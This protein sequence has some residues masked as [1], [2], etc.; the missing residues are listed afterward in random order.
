MGTP[1]GLADCSV[2]YS[3]HGMWYNFDKDNDS[4]D[5]RGVAPDLENHAGYITGCWWDTSKACTSG[6]KHTRVGHLQHTNNSGGRSVSGNNPTDLAFQQTTYNADKICPITA[7]IYRCRSGQTRYICK[8][9]EDAYTRDWQKCCS[10]NKKWSPK[11]GCNPYWYKDG[12]TF[13]NDCKNL[14]LGKTSYGLSTDNKETLKNDYKYGLCLDVLKSNV[15]ETELRKFCQ[16]DDAYNSETGEPVKDYTNICGCYY[17]K[18]Y[19]DKLIQK[20]KELYPELPENSYNDRTCFSTLCANSELKSNISTEQCPDQYFLRCINNAE[21]EAGGDMGGIELEQGNNCNIYVEKGN[22]PFCGRTCDNDDNCVDGQCN[23]CIDGVC[24]NEDSVS[25][26]NYTCPSNKISIS[27]ALCVG[28]SSTCNENDCCVDTSLGQSPPPS[29]DDDN[30]LWEN[31]LYWGGITLILLGI[32]IFI[33]NSF[34]LYSTKINVQPNR[35]IQS[36]VGGSVS[37]IIMWILSIVFIISGS[38]SVYFGNK[39]KNE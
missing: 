29:N 25:C 12:D 11:D 10:S 4:I 20:L 34:I 37:S 21:F 31:V 6:G 22:F 36:L 39:M 33:I 7:D 38:I 27:N 35:T 14:C 17:P 8:K 32:F 2:D 19:Y 24:K 15:D 30:D 16:S 5:N 28:D 9:N 18:D 1:G 13:S 23:S 3:G 26:S